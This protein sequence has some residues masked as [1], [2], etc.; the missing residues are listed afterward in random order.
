M[1]LLTKIVITIVATG[2]L[3]LFGSVY[4]KTLRWTWQSH[5]DTRE[6]AKQF[7]SEKPELLQKVV[8]RDDSKIYQNGKPVGNI[9][10]DVIEEG[11][12][13]IFPQLTDTSDFQQDQVFEYKRYKLKVQHIARSMG[14]KVVSSSSGSSVKNAVLE[15]VVCGKGQEMKRVRS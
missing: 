7:L 6:T 1:E 15:E 4:I 2:I 10:G 5:I 8:I 12:K 3:F 14:M 11:D 9:L 13:I